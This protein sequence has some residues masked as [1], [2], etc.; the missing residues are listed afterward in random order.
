MQQTHPTDAELLDYLNGQSSGAA[1]THVEDHLGRCTECCERAECLTHNTP[2]Q[3]G[4]RELGDWQDTAQKGKSGFL[5]LATE[6]HEEEEPPTDPSGYQLIGKISEGGSGVVYEALDQ[7]L[8]RKVALKFAKG[9]GLSKT[10]LMRFS[11]EANLAASLKHPNIVEVHEVFEHNDRPC[12]AMELISGGSLAQ[13]IKGRNYQVR[14]A[15][16][17]VI[18]TARAL[19]YAHTRG[20]VHRDIKPANILLQEDQNKPGKWSPKITDFGL[21]RQEDSDVLITQVGTLVGT[22]AYM[23]PEQIEGHNVS[24]AADVYALGCILYELLTYRPP[25]T[26]KGTREQMRMVLEQTPKPARKIVASVPVDLETVC[27]KCLEKSPER[28]YGSAAELADDLDRFLDGF[29]VG[30]RR[31]GILETA[32]KACRRHPITTSLTAAMLLVVFAAATVILAQWRES[33]ET[34][35]TLVNS[36]AQLETKTSELETKT[37]ELS[38]A[39][40]ELSEK[41]AASRVREEEALFERAI[42]LAESGDVAQ[43]MLWMCEALRLSQY[44]TRNSVDQAAT[45][46]SDFQEMLRLNLAAW[47][48]YIAR[49]RFSY[50]TAPEGHI[51]TS[52]GHF[53]YGYQDGILHRWRT[54]RDKSEAWLDSSGQHIKSGL[55]AISQTGNVLLFKDD[56]G[57]FARFDNATRERTGTFPKTEWGASMVL[58]VGEAEDRILALSFSNEKVR[59]ELLDCRQDEPIAKR[60][61]RGLHPHTAPSMQLSPDGAMVLVQVSNERHVLR[62]SNLEDILA[63]AKGTPSA[64]DVFAA[65]SKSLW[66]AT[67]STRLSQL[68]TQNERIKRE[69]SVRPYCEWHRLSA[70]GRTLL[71]L[72]SGGNPERLDVWSNSRQSLLA[73]TANVLPLGDRQVLVDSQHIFELPKRLLR[74]RSRSSGGATGRPTRLR[75]SFDLNG[76]AHFD[77]SKSKALLI[78]GGIGKL[79]NPQTGSFCGQPIHAEP[80]TILQV[81]GISPDGRIAATGTW[82]KTG[83]SPS[84]VNLWDA[85]TGK[86]LFGLLAHTN[87]VSAIAFSPDSRLVAVG[88]FAGEVRLWDTATGQQVAPPLLH[89]DIVMALTFLPD[90]KHLAVGLTHDHNNTPGSVVWNLDTRKETPFMPAPMD[91]RKVVFAS[92]QDVLLTLAGVLQAWN[93]RTGKL[94]WRSED[95]IAQFVENPQRHTIIAATN[96]GRIRQLDVQTGEQVGGT[97]QQD[98]SAKELAVH[99]NG[100]FLASG[101][102]DGTARFWDLNTAKPIGPPVVHPDPI[103]AVSFSPSGETL[104]TVSQNLTTQSALPEPYPRDADSSIARLR[105]LTAAEVQNQSIVPAR[106]HEMELASTEDSTRNGSNYPIARFAEKDND[107]FGAEFHLNQLLLEHPNEW[108]LF[109]RHARA[110]ERQGDF[111]TAARSYAQAEKLLGDDKHQLVDWYK[112][113]ALEMQREDE[114]KRAAWYMDKIIAAEQDDWFWFAER[115]IARAQ[116]GL[117]QESDEDQAQAIVLSGDK[118]YAFRYIEHYIAKNQWEFARNAAAAT[119]ALSKNDIVLARSLVLLHHKSN[120]QAELKPILAELPK[121]E[122]TLGEFPDDTFCNIVAWTCAIGDADRAHLMQIRDRLQAFVSKTHE[123]EKLAAWYNTLSLIH[124]RLGDMERAIENCK[125]VI[126]QAGHSTEWESLIMAAAYHTLGDEANCQKWLEQAEAEPETPPTVW[127]AIELEI[128]RGLIEESERIDLKQTPPAS[129]ATSP[130]AGK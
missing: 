48:P 1:T 114:W 103:A 118:F 45:D 124:Y 94:L 112:H 12:I 61:F 108:S 130:T 5:S 13:L 44:H 76:N 35:K 95:L 37:S 79:V 70:D 28:R 105:K 77:R 74:V 106:I 32:A 29:P 120:R 100:R 59:I 107:W 122:N 27:Q 97:M 34:N 82:A 47:E 110:R 4:L 72:G 71:S 121:L 69:V 63:V 116:L 101:G 9:L 115:S 111:E 55:A 52:D 25:F 26:A 86:T 73:T 41:L 87:Y 64:P 53:L 16:Q 33:V 23:A 21:A 88:D 46:R 125:S 92:N 40:S 36:N 128:L 91:C 38:A 81:G 104:F 129:T 102:I 83:V 85:S 18:A 14:D 66:L 42:R 84:N 113:E 117:Q 127:E 31:V 67:S 49:H 3:M 65:D 2:L 119:F 68:N 99:P 51:A 11:R 54:D 123:S 109:A 8:Q 39:R 50:S 19:H 6:E 43:G 96:D 75:T 7:R 62:T 15:V 56:A 30:A 80:R 17:L 93:W 22:P 24:T 89:H 98:W 60:E 126:Q 10:G 20:V 58:V 90:G 57:A 78:G